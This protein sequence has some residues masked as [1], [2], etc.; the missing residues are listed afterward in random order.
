MCLLCVGA[1]FFFLP[2]ACDFFF[3]SIFL[4]SKAYYAVRENLSESKA[5]RALVNCFEKIRSQLVVRFV[6]GQVELIEAVKRKKV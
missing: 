4:I 6:D 2:I 5:F 1:F 3:L